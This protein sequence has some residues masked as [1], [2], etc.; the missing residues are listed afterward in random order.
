MKKQIVTLMAL[1]GLGV[2]AFGQ[3]VA[4][5]ADTDS[6]APAA[7]EDQDKRLVRLLLPAMV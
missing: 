4:T 2:F 7:A 3:Q 6:A 1:L 5:A